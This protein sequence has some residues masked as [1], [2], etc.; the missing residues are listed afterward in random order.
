MHN[1]SRRSINNAQRRQ[2]YDDEVPGVGEFKAVADRLMQTG[3]RYLERGRDFLA[4]RSEEM[5]RGG[6]WEGERDFH[7]RREDW[8]SRQARAGDVGDEPW[9]RGYAHGASHDR[10]WMFDSRS[11]GDRHHRGGYD[12]DDHRSRDFDARAEALQEQRLRHGRRARGEGFTPGSYGYGGEYRRDLG[13]MPGGGRQGGSS[14]GSAFDDAA[15]RAAR[16]TSAGGRGWQDSGWPSAD[17]RGRGPRGYQRSEQRILEDLCEQ[18]T[19]DPII[20]ASNIDVRCEGGRIILEGEVANRWMKRRAEDIADDVRGVGEVDNRLRVARGE[21]RPDPAA[22]QGTER[23]PRT[24]DGTSPSS[25][26]PSGTTTT[27]EAAAA[28][29]KT[30]STDASAQS[31]RGTQPQQPR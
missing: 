19:E 2:Q 14:G 18:L 3:A 27:P 26:A 22:M 10:D 23:R 1:P 8:M 12:Y 7:A 30:D 31:G 15:V 24:G 20:D 25:A 21:P 17:H 4:S 11:E 5:R 9:D 28:A 6:G 29:G 13:D 16:H